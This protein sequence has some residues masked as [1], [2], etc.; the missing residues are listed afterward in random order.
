MT[1][2]SYYNNGEKAN[3]MSRKFRTKWGPRSGDTALKQQGI[4]VDRDR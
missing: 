3:A 2:D 1:T 4:E